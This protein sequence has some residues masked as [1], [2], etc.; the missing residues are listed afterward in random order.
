MWWF[1]IIMFLNYIIPGW[2]M[3]DHMAVTIAGVRVTVMDAMIF[4]SPLVTFLPSTK[5]DWMPVPQVHPAFRWAMALLLV[6]FVA[7]LILGFFLLRSDM[8]LGLRWYLQPVRTFLVLPVAMYFGYMLLRNP[9]YCKPI[10][11]IIV[12]ASL[13]SAT[14]MIAVGGSRTAS[15]TSGEDFDVLR[16]TS[17]HA[18]GEG[19]MIAAG[20]I[21]FSLIAQIRFLPAFWAIATIIYASIG[22]FFLP[23]RSFWLTASITMGCAILL[24]KPGKWGRKLVI[25]SVIVAFILSSIFVGISLVQ[26]RTDKDLGSWV[27]KR[28]ESFFPDENAPHRQHPWDT[29]LP[30]LFLDLRLFAEEPLF[31]GGFGIYEANALHTGEW[32]SFR[33]TNWTAALSE[34]GLVG[35]AAMAVMIGGSLVA[36]VRIT[37][38]ATDKWMIFLGA[39]V[40]MYAMYYGTMGWFSGSWSSARSAA[41]VGM[42]T[43]LCFRCRELCLV[44]PQALPSLMPRYTG[45]EQ[46]VLPLD[47]YY[48]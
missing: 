17:N 11:I 9:A 44:M 5:F 7:D 36:G 18:L 19:G 10:V 25:T 29:R 6:T 16:D 21:A 40:A 31:G 2:L 35:F 30:G 27:S 13:A 38:Q 42:M 15:M 47:T 32:T 37:R 45:Y 28:L 12:L 4:L 14:S 20:L 24:F 46:T 23:H 34:T 43:G 39:I 48:A 8:A 1:A 33:H 26:S 3:N 41:T 22:M